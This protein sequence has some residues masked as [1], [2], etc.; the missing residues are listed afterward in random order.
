M[1]LQILYLK[2]MRGQSVE[3]AT[4]AYYGSLASEEAVPEKEQDLFAA[5]L[6]SGVELRL[7][8]I[9]KHIEECSKNWRM[10]RMA[11]VDRNVLRLAVYD[12]AY[13]GTHRAVA[14]KEALQLAEQYSDPKSVPFINGVLD[15]LSKTISK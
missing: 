6:V 5:E 1:A 9:D 12:M 13:I 3:E 15:G 14:I 4:E 10:E 8:E 2:D 11:A 7:E